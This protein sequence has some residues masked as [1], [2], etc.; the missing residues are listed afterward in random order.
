MLTSIKSFRDALGELLVEIGEEDQ[1]VAVVTADVG[2]STRAI[3][4]GEIFKDRYFNVGIS[5]QHMITFAAGLARAGAKPVVVAFAAFIMRAWEQIRNS[6][7][8]MN[9]NVKIVATH[10]GYSDFADGS[11]HQM[12][13]DIALMRVLPNMNVVVP[14]D[15]GDLRR[16]LKRIVVEVKNPTYVR[17]GRDYSPPVTEDMDYRC[18]LGKAYV[19]REGHD[20][21]IMGSGPILYEALQAAKELEK[22]GIS[23]AVV[24]VLSVKPIDREAIVKIAKSVGRIVTVE[25]HMVFGGVGSAIAE[26][27]AQEYPVPMKMIGAT[28]FGRSARSQQELLEFFGL[29]RK[30]IVKAC[31]E[32]VKNRDRNA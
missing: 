17:I 31:L 6:V 13:E 14:A 21:A 4:F 10:A 30:A 23:V 5:E 9:L 22:M 26:V 1:N 11:S 32:V 8:R 27:V 28:T 19:L 29:D 15:V 12:L 2:K 3:K 20:V 18:E 24:N 16:C 25:E 7:A